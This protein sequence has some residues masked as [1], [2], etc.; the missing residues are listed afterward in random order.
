VNRL[1]WKVLGLTLGNQLHPWREVARAALAVKEMDGFGRIFAVPGL[2][3]ALCSALADPGQEGALSALR[4]QGW[5]QQKW[6]AFLGHWVDQK[7]MGD[8][9][10]TKPWSIVNESHMHLKMYRGVGVLVCTDEDGSSVYLHPEQSQGFADW[11]SGLLGETGNVRGRLIRLVPPSGGS[12]YHSVRRHFEN[13]DW[14]VEVTDT[15]SRPLTVSGPWAPT[16]DEMRKILADKRAVLLFGPPGAGK[17]E[18]AVQMARDKRVILVPGFVFGGTVRGQDIAKLMSFFKADFLI[19]DDMPP[20]VAL[21]A[22]EQFEVLMR[23]GVPVVITVMTDGE[24]PRLPGLRPGRVD[25][26]F[27]FGVPEA[28]GRLGLLN[29][30]APG[31]DWSEAAAHPLA[32]GMTPAYLKELARRVSHPTRP[33]NWQDA[34]VSLDSQRKIAT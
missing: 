18:S 28:D 11:F 15:A 17:T 20:T 25:R 1:D 9:E 34:L 13:K 10:N 29:F 5:E 32:E 8:A 12:E 6:S 31:H 14:D 4:V 21:S 16:L 23:Q 22:L 19:V 33:E 30:F 3:S 24:L 26:M 7:L 2:I 27:Q